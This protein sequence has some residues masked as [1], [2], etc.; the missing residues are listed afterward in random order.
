MGLFDIFKKREPAYDSTNIKVT[1]L[2]KNFIFDY[3]MTTWI[4]SAVY[5]YDWGDNCFSYEF[6]IESELGISFLSIEEDESLEMCITNKIKIH[7][8]DENLPNYISQ[9]ECPPNKLEYNGKTFYFEEES[10][11]YF[12]NC[13]NK[14]ESW[15]EFIEWSYYSKDEK[16]VLNIEQWGENKFEASYGKVVKEYE[17]TNI[18]PQ[19]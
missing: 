16:Y 13:D 12:N 19:K 10:F 9:N 5:E 4:V 17:I 3:N 2:N 6:K 8:I 11:G 1:D 15:L 18:Y 14:Q 7:H